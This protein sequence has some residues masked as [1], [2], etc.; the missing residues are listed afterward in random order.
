[1]VMGGTGKQYPAIYEAVRNIASQAGLTDISPADVL[2][3]NLGTHRNIVC[4]HTRANV[5]AALAD[6]D[7][8]ERADICLKLPPDL[9]NPDVDFVLPKYQALAF[10]LQRKP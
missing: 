7:E 8:K 5:E 3:A 10:V 1:V 9:W 4:D 6:F 2:D